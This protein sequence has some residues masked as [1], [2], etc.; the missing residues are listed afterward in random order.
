MSA[1]VQ[2]PKPYTWRSLVTLLVLTLGGGALTALLTH[3]SMDTY[4]TLTKPTFAP[5]EWVFPAAWIVLYALMSIS[6]WLVLR[7]GCRARYRL[8]ALYFIQLLINLAWPFLFFTLEAFGLAFFW[9]LL[10]WGLV[11]ILMLRTFTYTRTGGWL[12]LPYQLWLTFAALLNFF[13]ARLN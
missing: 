13:I 4:E 10:L 5:P 6:I 9:L 3:S 11:L 8:L 7:T 1:N 12:L 2:E